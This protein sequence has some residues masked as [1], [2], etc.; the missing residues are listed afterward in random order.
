MKN[1]PPT[2]LQTHTAQ[3]AARRSGL[4]YQV[5]MKLARDGLV[6]PAV[7]PRQHRAP[8]RW[9]DSDIAQ[10]RMVG[11]LRGLGVSDDQIRRLHDENPEYFAGS[12]VPLT[13]ADYVDREGRAIGRALILLSKPPVVCGL[14]RRS[15]ARQRHPEREQTLIMFPEEREHVLLERFPPRKRPEA[16]KLEISAEYLGRMAKAARGQGSRRGK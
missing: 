8:T 12:W 13:V 7:H 6:R 3:E 5:L 16:H 15:K 10:A 14:P 11:Q 1:I 2:K 9:T 4:S